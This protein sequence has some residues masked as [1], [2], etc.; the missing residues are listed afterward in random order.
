MLKNVDAILWRR[1]NQATFDSLN[2]NSRGQYD[3]RLTRGDFELFFLGVPQINSTELGG[4]DLEVQFQ[5][6]TGPQPVA[7]TS[8][9]IRF[10]GQNSARR[11]WN[12]PSQRPDTAYPLWRPGRGVDATFNA[13]AHEYVLIARDIDG[14]FHA[15]WIKD[16]AFS[17]L[18]TN[19]QEIL[20]S[21]EVA[22]RMLI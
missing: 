9:T 8:V 6:F 14:N 5:P 21:R 11:D 20:N 13:N 1:C 4:F 3:I 15:R 22:W 18:P 17:M 10:M 16:A 7:A 12:I 19:V 2:G